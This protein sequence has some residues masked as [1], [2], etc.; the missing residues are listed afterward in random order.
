M[1]L[2]YEVYVRHEV[3]QALSAVRDPNRDRVLSF[4]ESL[5]NDPFKEGDAVEFDSGGR[6]HQI[7][8]IGQVALYYWPDHAEKEIRIV[9][10][11]DANELR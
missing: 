2:T 3:Y 6:R 4:I 9:D 1:K 10:L 5:A 11:V 8:L 7:K